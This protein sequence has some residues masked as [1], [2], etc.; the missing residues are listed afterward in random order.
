M[1][2]SIWAQ[3]QLVLPHHTQ[4]ILT[5]HPCDQ[6]GPLVATQTHVHRQPAGEVDRPC[7]VKATI[8][9]V[10]ITPTQMRVLAQC[11]AH[12]VLFLSDPQLPSHRI[13]P[14]YLRTCATKAGRTMP[15]PKDIDTGYKNFQHQHPRPRLNEHETTNDGCTEQEEPTSSAEGW[16]PPTI[17]LL[18]PNGHKQATRTVQ[19]HHAPSSI[20]KHKAQ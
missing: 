1:G 8:T 9:V 19:R 4:A 11:G 20:T 3:L 7:R 5:N 18:A 10:Y 6:Q 2:T 12:H 14:A 13:L 16:T 17:L 15:G